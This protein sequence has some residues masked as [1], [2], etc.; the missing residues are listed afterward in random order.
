MWYDREY[1]YLSI[2]DAMGHDTVAALLA[3]LTVGALRN[4]R[5]ALGSPAE[6]AD[7]PTTPCTSTHRTSSSRG[8][9]CGS[10]SPMAGPTW[11][12][13]ATLSPSFY[14]AA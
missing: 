8:C 9:S 13:P 5:R 1:L 4:R 2:T 10:G 12:T 6:Q 14:E 11:S 3:T 7:A